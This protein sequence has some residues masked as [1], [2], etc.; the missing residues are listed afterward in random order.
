MGRVEADKLHLDVMELFIRAQ[1][2]AII[3]EFAAIFCVFVLINARL[4][5]AYMLRVPKLAM[6][7]C[8]PVEI[9]LTSAT[10]VA[11]PLALL[12]IFREFT[13]I[14]SELVEMAASTAILLV[15]MA[16]LLLLIAE[17]LA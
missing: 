8:R 11:R 4:S 7:S 12:L 14:A 10:I 17:L 2:V 9:P 16:S 1:R 3:S 5:S 13:L 6:V 15:D